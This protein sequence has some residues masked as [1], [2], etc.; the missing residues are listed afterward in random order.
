MISQLILVETVEKQQQSQ[1]K[2]NAGHLLYRRKNNCCI[3]FIP[4]QEGHVYYKHT[5]QYNY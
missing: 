4:V 1:L 3:V 5:E 2:R